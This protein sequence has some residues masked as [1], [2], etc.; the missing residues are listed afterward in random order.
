MANRPF[1]P[2]RDVL[3]A[4]L[5]QRHAIGDQELVVGATVGLV[6]SDAAA[7]SR[8]RVDHVERQLVFE[9]AMAADAQWPRAILE[10]TGETRHVWVVTGGTVACLRRR[11]G[12]GGRQL[13]LE[14]VAIEAHLQ[15]IDGS[16]RWPGGL[17]N[18]RQPPRGGQEQQRRQNRPGSHG[19][20]SS[21]SR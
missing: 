2:L 3:V 10:Q 8:R 11:V 13:G 15:L 19:D 7:F 1:L 4:R 17:G 21:A 5:A 16:H 6:A 9:V 20:A 12:D 14:I 18:R